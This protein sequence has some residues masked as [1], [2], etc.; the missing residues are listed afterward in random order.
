MRISAQGT[1]SNTRRVGE[2]N[3]FVTIGYPLLRLHFRSRAEVTQKPLSEIEAALEEA[4]AQKKA[5]MAA[6]LKDEGNAQMKAGEY[7][8]AVDL[9]TKCVEIEPKNHIHYSNDTSIT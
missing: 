8:A 2:F 1:G 6:V 3:L 4:A 9:Y 5:S 7:K